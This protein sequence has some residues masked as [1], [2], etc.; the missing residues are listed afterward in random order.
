MSMA[1]RRVLI[2][3]S[4]YPTPSNPGYGI[5]VKNCEEGLAAN[6]F[7]SERAVVEATPR[8]FFH[9]FALYASFY[10]RAV[11]KGIFGDYDILY[12]HFVS[13]ICIPLLIIGL[14]RR[15][16]VVIN[17][18]GSDVLVEGN[19][20]K[21][22]YSFFLF[23]L[24]RKVLGRAAL[25]VTPSRQYRGVLERRF[26]VGRDKIFVSPSGG[27]DAGLFRPLARAGCRREL[28]IKEDEFVIGYVS[29]IEKSKGWRVLVDALAL[30]TAGPSAFPFRALFVGKGSE[31]GAFRE[32]ISELGLEGKV[33]HIEN[34][35]RDRLASFYSASDVFI[36]PTTKESLGL[37]GIE[38]MACGAPVIGS[39]IE[40]LG[41]Y[42][43]EGV[44]GMFFNPGDPADLA[45]KIAAFRRPGVSKKR[46]MSE[47]AMK[48]AANFDSKAVA[49]KLAGRLSA[50]AA[51]KG[52]NY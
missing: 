28:G 4:L 3:S 49:E 2:V 22:I 18:H 13:H 30:L 47:K 41:E 26:G 52:G 43:V 7:T 19:I 46:E 38:A 11:Y 20:R 16:A 44:T 50:I 40:A 36:F 48:M 21:F 51:L 12:G 14:F 25:V 6:G 34:T 42:V 33:I 15:P 35:T 17:I 1:A 27:V 8:G 29:R 31:V 23:P 39:R 10:A 45:D 5:F 24:V 37:V 9:K 32:K